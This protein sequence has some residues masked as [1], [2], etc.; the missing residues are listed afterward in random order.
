MKSK[1]VNR[2]TDNLFRIVMNNH[3]QLSALA[4]HKA[5]M[6]ITVCAIIIGLIVQYFVDPQLQYTA[7]TMALTCLLTILFA[8]YS[9]LPK[10]EGKREGAMKAKNPNFNVI[11]FGDFTHLEYPDFERELEKVINDNDLIYESLAKDLYALGRVLHDKKYRFIRYSYLTFMI[12]L[13][14]SGIVLAFTLTS[15][16]QPVQP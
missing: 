8:V 15:A 12:G 9:T 3:L 4:D 16:P 1:N 2:A 10:Y 6:I 11:F 5:S 7:L 14:A 13:V